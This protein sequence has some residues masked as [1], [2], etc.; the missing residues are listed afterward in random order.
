MATRHS[1]KDSLIP[2]VSY[3]RMSVRQQEASP[4]QQR[5][6]VTKLAQRHGYR[7]DREYF[8][9]AISGDCTERRTAFLEMR[10][11]AQRGEFKAVICWDQDRFGRFDTIDAGYWIKPFRDF[12]VVLVTV[13]Q[14]MVSW[15]DFAGRLVYM[16]QQ[17]GKHAYLR[18]LSR[19]VV[20]GQLAGAAHGL[21]QGGPAPYGYKI[22][23]QRLV[24]DPRTAPIV[25]RIYQEL[26]QGMS[27][28]E[29]ADGLNRDGI[30]SPGGKKWRFSRIT[31]L[32]K[33]RVYTGEFRYGDEPE[34]RYHWA[35]ASGVQD[36][37]NTKR[38]RHWRKETNPVVIPNAHKALVSVAD[39]DQVQRILKERT[40]I[41]CCCGRKYA[42]SCS[43]PSRSKTRG[44][45]GSRSRPST[46]AS[47][48]V[49]RRC[50]RPRLN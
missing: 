4:D 49:L 36:G 7:I 31:K 28:R 18:D 5:T 41:K 15:T 2:A 6:E 38:G 14:G 9:E 25:H 33:K 13:V 29:V 47:T 26:L 32:V 42:T 27:T 37:T 43:L 50:W 11:A 34:G 35:S 48:K 40:R 17:E 30:P 8:D 22:I 1:T 46:S 21:W 20:R 45:C 16:V 12:N 44:V 39:F 24:P 23:A 3:I 19:N 10:E